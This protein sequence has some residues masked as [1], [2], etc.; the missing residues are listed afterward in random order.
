VLF[1]I[2][3]KKYTNTLTWKI[4][5]MSVKNDFLMDISA[6]EDEITT[7]FRNVRHQSSSDATP[8]PR[9]KN[10]DLKLRVPKNT[11]FLIR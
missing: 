7:L 11:D 8:H 5:E 9:N 4:V 3:Q 6:L 10:G 2:K 1:G